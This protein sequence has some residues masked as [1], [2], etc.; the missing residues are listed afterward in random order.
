MTDPVVVLVNATLKGAAPLAAVKF[1]TGAAG[2]APPDATG[3]FI[4]V[5]ISAWLRARLY[6]RTSSMLPLKYWP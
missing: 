5:W 3:V 2:L 4:S 6:T 1:C